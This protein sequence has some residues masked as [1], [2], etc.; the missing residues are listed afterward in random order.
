MTVYFGTCR[1]SFQVQKGKVG[2]VGYKE[3][4]EERDGGHG[5]GGH[6][7]PSCAQESVH[8]SWP[9]PFPIQM[10]PCHPSLLASQRAASKGLELALN[11]EPPCHLG[12]S[13]G[14]WS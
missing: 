9:C 2:L 10:G 14:S 3:S 4:T 6:H 8:W 11:T 7:W 13:T 1:Y 12:F 5:H